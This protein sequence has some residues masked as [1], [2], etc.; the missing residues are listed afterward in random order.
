MIQYTCDM[1]FINNNINNNYNIE[2]GILLVH[3]RKCDSDL[4]HKSDKEVINL[5]NSIKVANKL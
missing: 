2:T 5:I 1:C 4:K 3:I